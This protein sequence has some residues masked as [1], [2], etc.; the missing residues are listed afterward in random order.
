MLSFYL[1]KKHANKK[2]ATHKVE[3]LFK[4]LINKNYSVFKVIGNV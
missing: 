1:T 4:N 2:K 3:L